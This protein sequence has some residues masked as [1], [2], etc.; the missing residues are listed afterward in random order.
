M[1]TGVL[2]YLIGLIRQLNL[3]FRWKVRFFDCELGRGSVAV[4]RRSLCRD[5]LPCLETMADDY[6]TLGNK[7]VVTFLRTTSIQD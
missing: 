1:T 2:E 3:N 6:L 5:G 7:D 4:F